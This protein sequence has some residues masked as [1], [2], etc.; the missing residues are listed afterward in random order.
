MKPC[1]NGNTQKKSGQQCD[2][3]IYSTLSLFEFPV[4]HKILF[5]FSDFSV[6]AVFRRAN[7]NVMLAGVY[8]MVRVFISIPSVLNL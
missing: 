5:H 3:Y 7:F 6:A 4:Q 2:S 1:M 8:L